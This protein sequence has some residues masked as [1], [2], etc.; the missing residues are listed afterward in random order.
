MKTYKTYTMHT[1]GIPIIPS[2]IVGGRRI[3]RPPPFLHFHLRCIVQLFKASSERP[4]N[5]RI[6]NRISRVSC[7]DS[8]QNIISGRQGINY[9]SFA[10]LLFPFLQRVP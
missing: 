4:P 7:H 1:V 3:T 5:H 8:Q 10:H 9:H 6:H 2:F